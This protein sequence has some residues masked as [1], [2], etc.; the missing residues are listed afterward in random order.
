MARYSNVMI[1]G[2]SSCYMNG[3]Q[4]SV[5][6][7]EVYVDGVHYVPADGENASVDSP[8]TPGK[9]WN[10]R[11]RFPTIMI[12][13]CQEDSWMLYSNRLIKMRIVE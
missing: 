2:M 9:W 6:D 10:I 5:I 13:S 4:I 3:R 8:F 11:L 7:G 12:P 1:G